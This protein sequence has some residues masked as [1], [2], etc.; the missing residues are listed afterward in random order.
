MKD[1]SVKAAEGL[2]IIRG[3]YDIFDKVDCGPMQRFRFHLFYRNIDGLW[4]TLEKY[5]EEKGRPVGKLHAHSYEIDG[6]KRVLELLYCEQCGTLFYGGKRH[7]YREQGMW[8]T[9]ILPTSSN[10]EDLPE[11]QS[12]VMVEKRNY[13]EFAIFYPVPSS[14]RDVDRMLQEVGVGL[15]HKISFNENRE[16]LSCHWQLAFLDEKRDTL[17]SLKMENNIPASE[18]F[19]ILWKLWMENKILMQLSKLLHYLAIV[20]IALQTDLEG[21]SAHLLEDSELVS[22]KSLSYMLA[23]CSTSAYCT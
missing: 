1:E 14:I 8:K 20:H 23:N 16:N 3:L 6:D 7:A 2:V 17:L 9:D 21:H 13:H 5:D 18:A 4:A 11:R 12:Q 19:Y 10:L 15:Q 22:I